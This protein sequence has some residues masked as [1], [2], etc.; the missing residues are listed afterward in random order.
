VQR[1]VRWLAIHTSFEAKFVIAVQTD[2]T[3]RPDSN[4]P[5]DS[6]S[7]RLIELERIHVLINSCKNPSS[8]ELINQA[9]ALSCDSVR[10]PA[11]GAPALFRLS[12]ASSKHPNPATSFQTS[13][14]LFATNCWD[15]IRADRSANG[16][17]CCVPED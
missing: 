1:G 7:Y 8:H 16:C 11:P 2:G 17:A 15:P 3:D 14:L 10:Y 4:C 13:P 6:I 9:Q 12:A 5:N